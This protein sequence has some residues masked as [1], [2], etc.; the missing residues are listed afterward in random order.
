MPE[1]M[2]PTASEEVQ[3][4]AGEEGGESVPSEKERLEERLLQEYK[5]QSFVAGDK[6]ELL[7][8]RK[9]EDLA[10]ERTQL[11]AN[12]EIMSPYLPRTRP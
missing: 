11:F 2:P 9:E 7:S 3:A 6:T 4:A 5:S 8:A 1:I 10:V 12:L